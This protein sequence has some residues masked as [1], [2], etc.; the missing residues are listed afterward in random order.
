MDGDTAY[1]RRGGGNV[2]ANMVMT[3]D[4]RIILTRIPPGSSIGKHIQS[5]GDDVN[6]VLEGEGKA[7]CDGEEEIL[8]PGVCHVCPKGSEHSIVNDGEADLTLFTTVPMPHS[9]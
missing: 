1:E 7:V 5:T 6:Y 4:T 3:E 9:P 8:S 2:F